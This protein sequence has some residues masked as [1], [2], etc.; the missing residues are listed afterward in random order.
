MGA[1]RR[2]R[3]RRLKAH[4]AEMRS[5]G[6]CFAEDIWVLGMDGAPAPA[7]PLAEDGWECLRVPG[8]AAIADLRK[9]GYDL[10]GLYDDMRRGAEGWADCFLVFRD[11][12]LAHM[13]QV[14]ACPD[15]PNV[16]GPLRDLVAKGAVM[17][18]PCVT[19]KEFRGSGLY[20]RVLNWIA[21]EMAQ[22]GR[23]PVLIA[24]RLENRPSVRGVLK[25]GYVPRM[26]YHRRRL[27]PVELFSARP[28]PAEVVAE[29]QRSL[30]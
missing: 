17:V 29:L 16:Y 9:Q 22:A 28:W 27:G 25:G 12:R 26:V 23:A 18:G 19:P 10:G 5:R 13:S 1:G 6:P 20:G 11:R 7:R 14:T 30:V 8:G 21:A 15:N 24:V 4:L 2:F 3:L